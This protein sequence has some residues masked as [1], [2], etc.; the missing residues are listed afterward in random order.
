MLQS[1]EVRKRIFITEI[2]H[3]DSIQEAALEHD[4]DI[5]HRSRRGELSNI[6][7]CRVTCA[8]QGYSQSFQTH[9]REIVREAV[10]GQHVE[11][12]QQVGTVLGI[13][14]DTSLTAQRRLHAQIPS[15]LSGN[16]PIY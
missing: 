5:L 4:A 11:E 2:Q 1:D 13:V 16:N 8:L 12:R 15:V 3:S 14:P 7:V 9:S 6:R 10:D